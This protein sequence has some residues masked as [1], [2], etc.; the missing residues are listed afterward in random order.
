MWVV[1]ADGVFFLLE[2]ITH[3]TRGRNKISTGQD[4]ET[5]VSTYKSIGRS[6]LEYGAPIWSPIISNNSW[7]KLQVV[8]NQALRIATGCLKMSFL[9]NYVFDKLYLYETICEKSYLNGFLRLLMYETSPWHSKI[10]EQFEY[11]E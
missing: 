1:I 2:P 7:N 8:Q 4:Q 11:F 10:K 9:W 3:K 6:V 5:L